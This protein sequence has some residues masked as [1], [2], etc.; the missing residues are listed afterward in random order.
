MDSN[1]GSMFWRTYLP[2]FKPFSHLGKEMV[3]LYIQRTT[4]HFPYPPQCVVVYNNKV[5]TNS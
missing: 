5:S 1:S 2:D 4:S 3:P